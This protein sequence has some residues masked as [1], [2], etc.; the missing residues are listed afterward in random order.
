MILNTVVMQ[1]KLV[2][3]EEE[4]ICTSKSDKIITPNMHVEN[5]I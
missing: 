1:V 4:N 2:D 3:C 5:Q